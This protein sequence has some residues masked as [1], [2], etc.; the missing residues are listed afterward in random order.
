M[1]AHGFV[2]NSHMEWRVADTIGSS[3]EKTFAV[4]PSSAAVTTASKAE[5]AIFEEKPESKKAILIEQNAAEISE[6]TGTAINSK[7]ESAP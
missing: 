4:T 7:G 3:M 5:E 6:W 1:S 2:V